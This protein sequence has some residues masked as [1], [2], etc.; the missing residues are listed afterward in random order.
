[1]ENFIWNQYGKRLAILNTENIEIC[2][3]I[4]KLEAMKM[5]FVSI[6][7][8]ICLMSAEIFPSYC[9]NMP[10]MRL[11]MS[12]GFC[13][14]FHTLYSSATF[15]KSVKIWQGYREFKGGISFCDTVYMNVHIYNIHRDMWNTCTVQKLKAQQDAAR[16][17]I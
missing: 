16:Q 7:F 5:L 14:K 11:V 13:S 10:K 6:F 15:W 12:Y 2:G 1:M 4:T 8:H 9:S 17:M 3:W